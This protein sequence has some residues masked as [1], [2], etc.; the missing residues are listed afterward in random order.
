MPGLSDPQNLKL[1]GV[2][3]VEEG[4]GDAHNAVVVAGDFLV[5]A[6]LDRVVVVVSVVS[7]LAPEVLAELQVLRHG[8]EGQ[9]LV[10]AAMV[11]ICEPHDA[12]H[13][14]ILYAV[15]DLLARLSLDVVVLLHLEP[16]RSA[17]VNSEPQLVVLD[18]REN[19]LIG[20]LLYTSPS[21]RDRTRSRMPSSA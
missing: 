4:D 11:Q 20:C 14:E 5:G 9:I 7:R 16:L 18:E 12:S 10:A 6:H 1:L 2:V 13:A 19:L 8:H 3:L 15:H 17:V 21:P